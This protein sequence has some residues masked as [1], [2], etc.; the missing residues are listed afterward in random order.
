VKV[1]GAPRTKPAGAVDGLEPIEIVEGPRYVSRAG[2]K[3]AAALDRFRLQVVGQRALDVGAA[4]GGFTD[5]LLQKGAASVVAVDVGNAQFSAQLRG[6]RRVIVHESLD[7]RDAT[8]AELGE[9]FDLIVV[10]V[11]FI[12]LC[13]LAGS[14]ERWLA[15]DGDLIVLVK[16]QFEV[17][18]E[19]VG[20][21]VVKGQ[22][23]RA[24]AVEKVI[25]CYSVVGLDTVDLTPSPLLGEH[26][27]QEYLLW[28][29]KAGA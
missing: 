5:C 26:G 1:A 14:M 17:G 6:D 9:P 12:S 11:S 25:S 29:R 2:V 3:L 19:S 24:A 4:T 20:R 13:A 21:G 27:N 23:P 28:L 10:D 22:E 7:I 15:S 18:R 8:P 16:P